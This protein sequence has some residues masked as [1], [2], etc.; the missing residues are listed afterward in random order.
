M[1][2]SFILILL[3]AALSIASGCLMAESRWIAKVGISLFHKGYNITKIWWQGAIAVFIVQ[4]IFF[5]IHFTL[6]QMTHVVIGRI[7]HF[8]LLLAAV[9]GLYLTCYDFQDDY[10][11]QL[12]GHHFHAGFYLIWAGW[13]MTA[14]YFLFSPKII[15]LPPFPLD[16]DA[17]KV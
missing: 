2:R 5:F 3:L 11:H 6:Y 4:L 9:G 14:I 12:L 8:I 17:P 13:M 7:I 15:K 10:T 16:K 1:K